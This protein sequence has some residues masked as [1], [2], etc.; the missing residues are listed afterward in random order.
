MESNF[1][2][3]E[4][5]IVEDGVLK[6]LESDSKNQLRIWT[7]WGDSVRVIIPEGVREI[8]TEV[9]MYTGVG[10]VTLPESLEVIGA[11]TFRGCKNLRVIN[12]KNVREI[13][14]FA[15]SATCISDL[16]IPKSVKSIGKYAFAFMDTYSIEFDSEC[17]DVSIGE[18][19]FFETSCSRFEMFGVEELPKGSLEF[20]DLASVDYFKVSGV[21]KVDS[22]VF[23]K[24]GGGDFFGLRK[25]VSEGATSVKYGEDKIIKMYH[26]E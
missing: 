25:A 12:L 17:C 13:G 10:S 15:F 26:F 5:F 23:W 16:Y 20:Y 8:D 22:D 6:D 9:F 18:K 2:I 14:D 3:K 24:D 19:C 11:N 1:V 4:G 21:K 7:D